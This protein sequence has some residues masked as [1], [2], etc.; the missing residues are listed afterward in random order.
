MSMATKLQ[1]LLDY[2]QEE[3]ETLATSLGQPRFRAAQLRGWLYRGADFEEMTNLPETFRKE[4]KENYA[5]GRLSIR[6]RLE[7]ALDGT[8]KYLLGLG[9]GNFVE[10]VLMKYKYGYSACVSTQVGC[11]MGCS[12]C[13]SAQAGFVRSLT[14]G[15]ILGQIYHEYR[16]AD[17]HRTCCDDGNRR[18]S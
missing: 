5:A 18:A 3:L 11:K 9:D 1:N 17:P 16:S 6:R 4:L 8:V 15:E 10:S 14:A 12:F 13:A 7:S 2:S